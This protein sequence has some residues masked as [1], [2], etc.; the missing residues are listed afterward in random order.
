[1]S[2]WLIFLLFVA[3]C[4]LV[5]WGARRMAIVGAQL[6]ASAQ[7]SIPGGP[8]IG[9]L[10]DHFKKL[11]QF[12][13]EQHDSFFVS[14]M[15]QDSKRFVQT[16]FSVDKDGNRNWQFDIPLNDLHAPFENKIAF[17]AKSRGFE[18]KVSSGLGEVDSMRFLDIDFTDRE[19][20]DAF[21]LWVVT[22][23]FNLSETD[24]FEISWG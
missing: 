18:A 9:T 11:S 7:S 19:A 21:T 17:E 16:A 13:A 1:M 5:S 22:K 12:E 6:P 4:V 2:G 24:M 8:S 15:H 23:V 3:V 20:H 10:E 14:V